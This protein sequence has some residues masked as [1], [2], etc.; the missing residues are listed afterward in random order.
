MIAYLSGKVLRKGAGYIIVMV[1]DVGYRVVVSAP[2]FAEI[3]SGQPM[4]VYV[5]HHIR[6][7]S[8]ALY[9]FKSPA[10]IDMFELLLTISGI[11]PKSALAVLSVAGI[12]DLRESIVRGD[13]SLLVKVS[14]IGKKTAERVVLELRDKIDRLPAGGGTGGGAAAGGDEI[15]ALVALGYS[16]GQAREALGQVGAGIKDSGERVREALKKLGR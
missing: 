3:E 9:G 11:G 12:D 2:Y 7:D 4:E 1:N 6:E 13:S 14:G 10:Q 5:Y 8:S 16:L 15:D